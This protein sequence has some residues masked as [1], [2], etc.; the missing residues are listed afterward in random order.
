MKSEGAIRER[1]RAG[2][3]EAKEG[4]L[5]RGWIRERTPKNSRVIEAERGSKH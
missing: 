2:L 4:M 5:G 3:E 1:E